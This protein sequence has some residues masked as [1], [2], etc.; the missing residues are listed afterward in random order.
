MGVQSLLCTIWQSDK[1]PARADKKPRSAGLI[2]KGVPLRY[3][4]LGIKG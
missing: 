1:K 2:P 4:Y 3:L